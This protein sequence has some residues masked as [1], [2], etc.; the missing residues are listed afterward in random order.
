MYKL[1]IQQFIKVEFQA[2][3]KKPKKGNMNFT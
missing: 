2:N 3:Q 1:E